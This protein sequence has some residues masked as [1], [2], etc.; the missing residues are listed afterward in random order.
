MTP[1]LEFEIEAGKFKAKR[2]IVMNL[3]DMVYLNHN[4]ATDEEEKVTMKSL[5][6]ERCEELFAVVKDTADRLMKADKVAIRYPKNAMDNLLTS[7][8]A[9]S[10]FAGKDEII[11]EFL[12]EFGMDCTFRDLYIYAFSV[13]LE[14]EKTNQTTSLRAK[15]KLTRVLLSKSWSKFDTL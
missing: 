7:I 9:S 3:S 14:W 5:W 15:E 13:I 12:E 2:R 6:K 1:Y 4:A 8:G 11:D 10:N